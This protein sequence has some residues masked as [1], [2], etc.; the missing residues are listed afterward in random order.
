M[1][2]TS[3]GGASL[4]P[5]QPQGLAMWQVTHDGRTEVALGHVNVL[6][7]CFRMVAKFCQFDCIGSQYATLCF[8]V[9]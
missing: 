9:R 1:V 2:K 5:P 8:K 7:I 6:S 3:R 4:T